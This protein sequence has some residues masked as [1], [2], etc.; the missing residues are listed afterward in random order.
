[1][2]IRKGPGEDNFYLDTSVYS[3]GKWYEFHEEAGE[4]EIFNVVAWG[5]I[6][7]GLIVPKLGLNY[8][9]RRRRQ[10]EKAFEE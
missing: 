2:V 3:G 1:M 9:E 4:V 7:M 5:N 10:A 8:I 6:S